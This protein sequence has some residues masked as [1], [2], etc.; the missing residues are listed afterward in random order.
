MISLSALSTFHRPPDR[1]CLLLAC[2]LLACSQPEPRTD[3]ES[4]PAE[5]EAAGSPQSAVAPDAETAAPA[6]RG[7][8]VLAEG[9]FRVLDDPARIP[10]LLDRAE[11]LGV[12]DL[13]VQVYRGGRAFYPIEFGGAAI[14]SVRDAE[15]VEPDAFALLLEA[16]H[17]RDLRVHAWVNVLSLSTRRD[18]RL[19]SELGRSAILVD[20]LGRSILDYPELEVPEPDRS[21]Y[22]MGT[23]GIYLDPA[24]PEVRKRLVA[25]F[26]E[27]VAR[28][29]GLDGLHL[30]YIRH[31]GV[32]PFTPGSRFGVGLDFGYGEASRAHYVTETGQADPIA[33][34]APGRV[35]GA[36]RWDAWRREKVTTL[37]E[38]IGEA[39]RAVQPG[40]IL[41]AAVIAYVDRAYLT[42]AQDWRSWLES[43][44]IDL[45]MPMVYTL[46]DRLLRYQVEN[47]AGWPVAERIWP[48]VGVW[49]LEDD[50]MRAL[51][52][53]EHVRNAGLPGEMYFSDDAIA[54]APALLAALAA[55]RP[56]SPEPEPE[57]EPEPTPAAP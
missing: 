44:A 36:D 3:V 26:R 19:V 34:L 4:E 10:I 28:Y 16:A 54:E 11:V 46:D 41:S 2:L 17:A 29:P 56:D 35:R 45:A 50:P 43:G 47:Y 49:L 52:Q 39:I 48:G 38:E 5:S 8:W 42:L 18:A 14:E 22:R 7:I 9:S 53:L 33:G 27:M 25:T 6:S 15:A 37:V 23:R 12:T 30:D 57:P 51:G 20:R 31:P 1:L 13:F 24:L 55:S 40:I 32:L 21:Y